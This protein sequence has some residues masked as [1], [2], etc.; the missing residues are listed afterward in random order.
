MWVDNGQ[1]RIIAYFSWALTQ[2]EQNYCVTRTELFGIRNTPGKAN[3]ERVCHG[4]EKSPKENLHNCEK[5]ITSC[6]GL[7]E[8]SVMFESTAQDFLLE[9]M[10]GCTTQ[11]A[12]KNIAPS[13][14]KTGIDLIWS[15][16]RWMISCIESR[17]LVADSKLYMWTSWH[18]GMVITIS[19]M[20]WTRTSNLKGGVVLHPG[21]S[22]KGRSL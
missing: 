6:I 12:R 18:P 5:L 11:L 9:I 15:W 7:D 20:D 17:N 19:I 2:L 22:R 4:N 1:E 14:R 13:Y 21:H 16:S 10:F 3:Y 8:D